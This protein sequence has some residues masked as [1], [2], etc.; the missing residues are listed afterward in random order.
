[1]GLK[2]LPST[3]PAT[4]NPNHHSSSFK[5]ESDTEWRSLHSP[6]L[7][8][9]CFPFP[10]E[11]PSKLLKIFAGTITSR[12]KQSSEVLGS[13]VGRSARLGAREPESFSK[14]ATDSPDRIFFA[15][16]N[17]AGLAWGQINSVCPVLIVVFLPC[18]GV[19]AENLKLPVGAAPYL[20][21]LKL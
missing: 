20:I 19:G 13:G 6:P 21:L 7:P 14:D 4:V 16:D 9:L 15:V 12:N 18:G 2:R 11:F 1:M 17:Q 10:V 3:Y 5:S 8:P